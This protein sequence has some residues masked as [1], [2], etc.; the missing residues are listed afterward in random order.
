MKKTNTLTTLIL[1]GTSLLSFNALSAIEL[2]DK[3]KNL[4]DTH[5][6]VSGYLKVDA[7][8]V[9]GDV[10]YQDYWVANIPGG[11]AIETSTTAF[12]FRESRLGIKGSHKDVSGYVEIDFYGGGGNEIVSNSTTPRIRHLFIEYKNWKVGQTWTTFMPLAAIPETLD[13]GGPH[14]GEAF[15]RQTLI[16]YTNG[17]WQFAIENPETNGDGDNG[18]SSSAVGLTGTDADPDESIPDFIGRYNHDAKWGRLTFATLFRIIDQGGLDETAFGFNVSGKI[19]TFKKDDLRFQ[20][21]HGD[22]GR[23]V[24]AGL[25]PDI[26]VNPTTNETEVE[27]TTAFTIS[28]RHFWTETMRTTAFYGS[29]QTDILDRKRNHWGINLIEDITPY[30]NIGAEFGN[31]SV[32]DAAI[33]DIDSNYFQL[34]AKF[35][36]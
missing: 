10:G 22:L 12:N 1:L 13:F 30:L 6:S 35:T 29:G 33:E 16:R 3:S 11:E 25:T 24:S 14:V 27:T 19:K 17:P 18:F 7:R 26:V 23:Y 4:P 32:D 31:Y 36:F 9:N 34:S 8:H 2:L 20:I 21:N 15:I 5:V 28:Y